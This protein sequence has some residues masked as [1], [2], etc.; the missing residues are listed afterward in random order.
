MNALQAH[1]VSY[2]YPKANS[3]SLN[4]ISCQLNAGEI[5]AIA[6]PNGSGK[7]TLLN[8]LAGLSKP[9]KGYISLNEQNIQTLNTRQ[10]AQQ[11]AFMGQSIHE[12]VSLPVQAV[13]ALGRLPW[14]NTMGA[15]TELDIKHIEEAVTLMQ[16]QDFLHRPLRCLSGGERQRVMLARTL[17]QASPYMLL[18][19][20][21]SALDYA[22]QWH[23]MR[24][25]VKHAQTQ[26]TGIAIIC[27]DLHLAAW[28]ADKVLLMRDGAMFAYGTPEQV[29]TEPILETV[30]QC[31]M[32]VFTRDKRLHIVAVPSEDQLE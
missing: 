16:I 1:D 20:P 6:G 5:L 3:L 25:L 24:T 17:C 7:S 27:H 9:T 14:Q 32:Q 23:V 31:P 12:N 28:F 4:N 15:T 8:I 21:T 22:H 13:V 26:S 11:C 19:E 29:L 10:K 2:I 30:Y 18:D